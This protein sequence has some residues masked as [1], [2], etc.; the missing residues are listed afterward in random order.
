M[1][2]DASGHPIK[3]SSLSFFFTDF[4]LHAKNE[5]NLSIPSESFTDQKIPAI[6]LAENIFIYYLGNKNL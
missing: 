3:Y 6:W 5:R 4:Y 1:S 2:N